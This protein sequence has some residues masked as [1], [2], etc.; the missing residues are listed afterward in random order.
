MS[1]FYRDKCRFISCASSCLGASLGRFN[2]QDSEKFT[3]LS[4]RKN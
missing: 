2:F 3:E 1:V 4:L